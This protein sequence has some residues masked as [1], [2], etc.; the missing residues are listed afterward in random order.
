KKKKKLKKTFFFK[1][2]KKKKKIMRTVNIGK[3]RG[4]E[5][6]SKLTRASQSRGHRSD[7][8][9]TLEDNN[10]ELLLLLDTQH[11]LPFDDKWVQTAIGLFEKYENL[12]VLGGFTGVFKHGKT[13]GDVKWTEQRPEIMEIKSFAGKV[14][15]PEDYYDQHIQKKE[16]VQSL[17][18]DSV[19]MSKLLALK[20]AYYENFE[21]EN[22]LA[23]EGT[24]VNDIFSD[25]RRD[26]RLRKD[27]WNIALA[28]TNRVIK[29][30]FVQWNGG[31][32]YSNDYDAKDGLSSSSQLKPIPYETKIKTSHSHSLSYQWVPFMFVTGVRFGPIFIRKNWWFDVLLPHLISLNRIQGNELDTWLDLEISLYTWAFGGNG[33]YFIKKKKNAQIFCVCV[34]VFCSYVGLYDAD[35]FQFDS[36]AFAEELKRDNQI[37]S[38]FDHYQETHLLSSKADWNVFNVTFLMLLNEKEL[39]YPSHTQT[40]R[41]KPFSEYSSGDSA[42]LI[43]ALQD[44]RDMSLKESLFDENIQK[45][46]QT[47][48]KK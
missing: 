40:L 30:R 10:M 44:L 37:D 48:N 45:M 29:E 22:V 20:K 21:L 18:E 12:Q 7:Q 9:K 4:F 42:R 39:N 13:F 17:Q 28:K 26:I 32:Y 1:K 11:T 5:R 46:L 16:H 15:D 19:I 33:T 31:K 8:S 47:L 36:K 3:L 23:A 34:C 25:Y 43:D 2:K 14:E 6:G 41:L 27:G 35:G 38:K 24:D